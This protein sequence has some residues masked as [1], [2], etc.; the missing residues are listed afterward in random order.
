LV[1]GGGGARGLAH[2]G[3]LRALEERG[4]EPDAIAG[5]STGGIV[6][7]A[8]AS[9]MSPDVA[10][11]TLGKLSEFDLLDFG[12]MGGIIGGKRIAKKMDEYL[13]ETFEELTIPLKVTA[14][15]V[16]SGELVILGSGPLVPALRATSALP[17]VLSPA[18]H[19]DRV[20]LDGGVL[21]NLPVDV[22]RTMTYSPVVAVDVAA[23][24]NRRL[25]FVT[26]HGFLEK[27]KDIKDR[28]FRTLTIELFMKSFD[29]PQALVTSLRLSM[30]PPDLLIRPQLDT[31]F[32]VEDFHRLEEA[33]EEGY[34][35]ACEALET[36]AL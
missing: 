16:Q 7:A 2:L 34:R 18:P 24:P 27:I 30:Q 19:M 5:C 17:G 11:D 12:A 6:G 26:K 15:D 14:V 29:I 4:Y 13:R 8:Y 3:V 31:Y 28:K 9:G 32:G 23:P 22:I 35:S 21:N 36:A 10:V 33:V 25:D 1:L 20:F